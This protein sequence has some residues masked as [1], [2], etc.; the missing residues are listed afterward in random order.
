MATIREIAKM[1]GVSTTTVSYVL[2]GTKRLSP[3]T[4][5][6]VKDAIEKL[7]Y[8]PNT[9]AQ[10]LRK[11]KT[12]TIGIITEDIRFF[13]TPDIING[14]GE[15]LEKV[16]YQMLVHDLHLYE[17][18]WPDYEKI[19]NY[20]KRINK[21]VQLLQQSMVSGIIYVCMHDRKLGKLIDPLDI[22][23]VYAYSYSSE[24]ESFVTYDD[25]VSGKEMTKHLID[26]G[27]KD[28]G[29]ICGFPHSYPTK[30]R[31]KGIRTA[32]GEEGLKLPQE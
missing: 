28:I 11:G 23:I 24:D 8:S 27:H 2:N 3:E 14:L 15:G 6:R 4:T 9:V 17:K 12:S 21:G 32:M 16:N 25:F 10:N 7:N 1:A 29:V 22:P 31:L 19:I 13:P 18:I 26:L 20:K 30:T 5:K